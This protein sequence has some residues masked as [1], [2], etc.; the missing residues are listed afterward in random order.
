MSS[1]VGIDIKNLKGGNAPFGFTN[2]KRNGMG[3]NI[4]T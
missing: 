2:G 1:V 4:L 3:E